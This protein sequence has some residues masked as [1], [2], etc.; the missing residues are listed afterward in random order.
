MKES[1]AATWPVGLTVLL[2]L[3]VTAVIAGWSVMPPGSEPTTAPRSTVSG[4]RGLKDLEVVA[5]RPHPVGSAAQ[6]DV[7][8]YLV[9]QARALGLSTEVQRSSVGG[10]R[11]ENVVVQVPGTGHT[12][13]DVLITSHYDSAPAAPGAGDDGIQVVAMLEALR[14]LSAGE[15]LRNDLVFLFTDGEERAGPM[16]GLGIQG[17]MRDHPLVPRLAVAFAFEC[18]P[19]SSGTTLRA[20][21]PGDAWL[22]G[23]LRQASPPV[24]ANSAINTSDRARSGNDF[25]AFPPTELVGAEFLCEGDQVRYHKAGDNVSAVD[26]GVVQDNGD[27]MVALARQFGN[28]DLSRAQRSDSDHVFFTAPGLGL[29]HYPTW[30]TQTLAVAAALALAALLVAAR[31]RRGI[32]LARSAL[33]S[34]AVLG[35]CLALTV[36]AWATWQLLLKLNPESQDTLHYPDFEKSGTAMTVI[37]GLA[38]V[39]Y[40]ATAHGL[41]RRTGALEYVAGG[42]LLSVL[43]GLLLAFAEPLFSPF[44]VWMAVG[45]VVAFAVAVF[46]DVRRWGAAFL[47]ALAAVPTIVLVTPLLAL[48]VVN[49]EQGPMVAVPVL[50]LVVGV[51]LPQLLLITGRLPEQRPQG[52]VPVE[53]RRGNQAPD[54]LP[55]T[56]L[57][58]PTKG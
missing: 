57:S 54:G 27:T 5:A 15:P 32:R 28:L 40:V 7:R 35:T 12:G 2:A 19:E 1:V 14:T 26:P 37:V 41:S 4:E 33:A 58:V 52:G 24:F 13:R 55:V 29:L 42:V 22:L 16:G 43:G 50:G 25:A 9:A 45:G 20:T 10:H 46:L 11:V 23:Q 18:T 21:T 17:F 51:L 30:V 6:H 44:A 34:L 47:L 31:R 56:S 53:S 36:L 49:V 3:A 38:L 48:E 39:A 8:D